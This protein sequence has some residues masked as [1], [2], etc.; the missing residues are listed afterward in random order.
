MVVFNEQVIGKFLP[1]S[2]S[3]IATELVLQNND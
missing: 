2:Y 1:N 3:S